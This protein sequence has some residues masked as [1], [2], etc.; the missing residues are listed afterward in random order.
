MSNRSTRQAPRSCAKSLDSPHLLDSAQICRN[1]CNWR[2]VT[3]SVASSRRIP[4]TRIMGR[5]RGQ[6][7]QKPTWQEV[8]RTGLKLTLC[9]VKPEWRFRASGE[10]RKGWRKLPPRLGRPSSALY[11]LFFDGYQFVSYG[12]SLIRR[13]IGT[14]IEHTDAKKCAARLTF[15]REA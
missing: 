2:E 5:R 7:Q 6:S 12:H 11:N 14:Q 13:V 1:G 8:P 9:R 3:S 10:H 15:P 4:N